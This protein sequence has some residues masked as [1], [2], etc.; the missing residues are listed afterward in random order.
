MSAISWRIIRKTIYHR[1][2]HSRDYRPSDV[3]AS[4]LSSKAVDRN[5]GIY[6]QVQLVQ[7]KMPTSIIVHIYLN[8]FYVNLLISYYLKN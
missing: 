6:N 1:D 5:K 8:N 3:I 7:F 4:V 2:S